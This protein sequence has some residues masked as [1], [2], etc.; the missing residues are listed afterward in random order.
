MIRV[1]FNKK[2][3]VGKSSLAVNL[4]AISASQGYRTLILDL[5]TQ[6]NSTAYLDALEAPAESTIADLFEQSITFHLRRRPA[7]EYCQATK[8]DNLF[9]IPGSQRLADLESE[10]DSRHKIYKLREALET[11]DNEFDHIYIDTAP[12]LNFYSLSALIAADNCLIPIDCDDFARQGLYSLQ[13]K[14]AEI[15]EDHNAKL[16]VEGIIANQFMANANLPKQIIDEL[17]EEGYPVLTEYISQ[18]VK[19]RESHQVKKPLIT[20]APK[21][22]LT[23]SL[24]AIFKL[25]EHGKVAK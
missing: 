1:L 3:G 15:K 21:H 13:Q 17:I 18:S 11:L 5:D 8:V 9:I 23:L 10:L 22:K 12:A 14:I 19:M 16:V 20:F 4:A 7:I 2:G 6:C 25:L 24:I